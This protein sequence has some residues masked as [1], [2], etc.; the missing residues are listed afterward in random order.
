MMTG[1]PCADIAMTGEITLRGRVLPIGG[2]KEKLLA[3]LRGGLKKVLIPEENAKD[4]AELPASVKNALE[5][6]PAPVVGVGDE[7]SSG[8]R[9]LGALTSSPSLSNDPQ[10]L[11]RPFV[12]RRA[13]SLIRRAFGSP[14]RALPCNSSDSG[15]TVCAPI[16]RFDPAGDIPRRWGEQ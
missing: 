1:I 10:L 7:D 2:L 11:L 14:M 3:A 15:T 12:L 13:K 8:V 6:V 4:L 9:A 5:I 16:R